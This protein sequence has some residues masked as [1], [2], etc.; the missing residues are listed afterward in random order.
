MLLAAPL[1]AQ[2]PAPAAVSARLE[3]PYR[4][5]T[6]ANGLT[7]ILHQ[8]RSVPVV[9]E[10]V[11]VSLVPEGGMVKPGLAQLFYLL[12]SDPLGAPLSGEAS[13]TENGQSIAVSVG[14]SGIAAFEHTASSASFTVEASVDVKLTF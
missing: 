3:V 1:R 9:A 2:A 7:G 12:F 13:V 11:L 8:D 10:P 5:F 14:P 6:L 4:L